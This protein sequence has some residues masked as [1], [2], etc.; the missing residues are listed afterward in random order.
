MLASIIICTHNPIPEYLNR[1]L[2]ALK[3]QIMELQSW[4]LILVDNASTKP[5]SNDFDISWHP[6]GKHVTEESV[7]LTHA[8]IKGIEQAQ[9]EILIFVDDDNCL[10]QDYLSIAV[11][12]MNDVPLFGAIG[13]GTII[14]EF[15]IDP[16]AEITP[17]LRSLALR[18]DSRPSYSNDIKAHN[19]L[20]FGAG[21]CIRRRI[22]LAYVKSCLLNPINAALGRTGKILL[23]G[24]DIDLALH[25]CRDGLLAGVLPELELVHLIPKKRTEPQYLIDL[26]AGHAASSY[27]LSRLWK[28]NEHPEDPLIKWGRYWKNR[29]RTKGLARKILIAEY[30]AEKEAK[31]TWSLVNNIANI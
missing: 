20:P 6:F 10:R 21:L 11:S 22:G 26:A 30:K 28:F 27:I 9:S 8:R 23:S 31:K 24:E 15:E 5:V 4:E 3:C 1:T 7:G 14:P 19:C 29:I 18:K 17:F 25:A 12:K 2:S 13:A 16:S